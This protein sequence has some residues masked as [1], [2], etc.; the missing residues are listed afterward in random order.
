M[1]S[2]VVAAGTSSNVTVSDPLALS[3]ELDIQDDGL[4]SCAGALHARTV[5]DGTEELQSSLLQCARAIMLEPDVFTKAR[6]T[7]VACAKWAAG[8]LPL[9][10]SDQSTDAE[11][12]APDSPARPE[13]VE[14]VP[15]G[16]LSS[17]GKKGMVHSIVRAAVFHTFDALSVHAIMCTGPC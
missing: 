11:T 3:L 17:G 12:S 10:P 8:D 5:P 15:P 2:A 7:F 4:P 1:A 16:K 6:L 9:A 14:M 13:Y